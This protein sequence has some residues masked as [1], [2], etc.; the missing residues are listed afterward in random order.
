[1]EVQIDQY[2]NEIFILI[3]IA[4]FIESVTTLTG[5][6]EITF[7]NFCNAALAIK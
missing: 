3:L 4:Y 7:L 5:L 2:G 1:M 6:G